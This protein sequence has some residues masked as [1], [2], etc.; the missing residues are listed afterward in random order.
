MID[1]PGEALKH[2]FVCEPQ[3]A[4]GRPH[5]LSSSAQLCFVHGREDAQKPGMALQSE[6]EFA[7]QLD[8]SCSN[9]CHWHTISLT[10][11]IVLLDLPNICQFCATEE[12]LYPGQNS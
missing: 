1:T 12:F 2:S 9:L 5:S 8:W 6:R 7:A 10:E 3:P 11:H 4:A